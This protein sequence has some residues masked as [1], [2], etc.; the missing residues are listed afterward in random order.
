MK[1]SRA[2]PS[3]LNF[4]DVKPGQAILILILI[5][6]PKNSILPPQI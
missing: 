3:I 4:P 1:N 2:L 6:S 5:N